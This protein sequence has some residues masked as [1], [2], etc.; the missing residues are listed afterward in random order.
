MSD[1]FFKSKIP[2]S[3]YNNNL[4]LDSHT[5]KLKECILFY[6]TSEEMSR[7]KRQFCKSKR[8]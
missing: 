8:L 5:D 1:N 6:Y 2:H 4:N 3:K 7:T